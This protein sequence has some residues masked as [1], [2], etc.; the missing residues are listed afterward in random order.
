M[1]EH[2]LV[3]NRVL[4]I[5]FLISL[6][7]CHPVVQAVEVSGHVSAEFR[8]FYHSP[9]DPQQHHNN[10][11]LAVEAEH[12]YEWDNGQQSFTFTPFAR[13]DEHDEER[14]HA[15]IRELT[16]VKAMEDMEWR[17]GIRKVFWGVTE[18]QH[19]VDIINQT[20]LVESPDGEAKLGQPMLNLALIHDWGTVDLFVLPYF[21][22][23][24]YPGIEGRLRSQPRVDVDQPVYAD[25]DKE[26]HIDY[27]LRWSQSSGD[28]DLGVSHFYGTSRVPRLVAGTDSNSNAVFI[29]HY[30]IINQTGIDVQ[31][32]KDAWLW[33]LEAIR[34]TG[35]G[36]GYYAATAG[37]E[38]TFYGVLESSA[39]VGLLMEYLYDDRGV[40]ATTPFE[41]DVMLGLRLILNDAQS[42]EAL[43]GGIFDMDTDAKVITVEA[44]RR[45]GN[46]WK[47][48]FD[49]RVY[50]N[51]PQTDLLYAYRNDDYVQFELVYYF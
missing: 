47:L 51:L 3:S 37:Y 35:Q 19:L 22:E 21:R 28:W 10:A 4:W 30:E 44:S 46:N 12:Y 27:A 36:V 38:Y 25:A 48:N 42:S 15:D 33:K 18:S 16:W 26:K 7:A 17:I 5:S 50:H 39:D 9:L 34:R 49:A 6:F 23:R 20:D 32:T 11:S 41:D 43:V 13:L 31:V 14:S 45:F 40:N 1:Q 2:H 24:T 29:P 8:S